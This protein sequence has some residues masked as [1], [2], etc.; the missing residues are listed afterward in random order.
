MEDLKTRGSFIE[1]RAKGLSFDKIAR[2]LQKSKQTLIDWSKEYEEEIANLKAVELE[3]L[4]EEY[5]LSKEKRIERFGKM[6]QRIEKEL[7][8]RNLSDVETDKLLE[9]AGKYYTLTREEYTESRFQTTEEMGETKK[10]RRALTTLTH[11]EKS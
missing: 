8:T 7:E 10:E 4:Y 3:A 5:F 2:Q 9:L 6:L 1:L 11:A